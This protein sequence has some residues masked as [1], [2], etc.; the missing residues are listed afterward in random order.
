MDFGL[1]VLSV[2]RVLV[3]KVGCSKVTKHVSFLSH[4]M[5]WCKNLPAS[6]KLESRESRSPSGPAKEV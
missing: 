6:E 5:C 4:Q 3:Y 1:N 2:S